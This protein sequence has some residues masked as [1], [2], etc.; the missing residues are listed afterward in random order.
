MHIALVQFYSSTP[1]PDYHEIASSLRAS[2]H[3]VWVGTPNSDGDLAWHD[4]ERVIAIQRGP[5][6]VPQALLRVRLAAMA[7]RRIM[8]LRFMRSVR[9]F[10]REASPDIVQVNPTIGAFLLPLF[11]PK[12]IR[13]ILDIRQINDGGGADWIGKLRDR[14]AIRTWRIWTGTIYDRACFATAAGARRVLG[15]GWSRW[16]SIVPVGVDQRFMSIDRADATSRGRE[17]PI[18]F[19]YVGTL[20]KYRRLERILFAVKRMVQETRDFQV[21]FLGPDHAEGFYQRL[22]DELNLNAV[23]TISPPV[24]YHDVPD[25]VSRYD[26][27]LAYVPCFPAWRY[28]PTIKV[29]EYR[30]LGMPMAATDIESNRE[31]VEDGVN[32]VLVEDSAEGLAE[33]M[34]RFVTD[35]EFLDRCTA[36]AQ[37]MRQGMTWSEV[38]KMY[39]Q[40]VYLRCQ[41]RRNLERS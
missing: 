3:T 18:R 27:A 37:K 5:A 36:N 23:V 29:L 25:A 21:V 22:V 31:F 13:F 17:H 9:G 38:A 35:R 39:E 1:T 20:S 30:A 16:A 15:E 32:G 7:L 12:R 41:A 19:I 33:G 40:D 28:Q 6:R 4:G 8:Y 10:L 2:G 26:V 24:R 14:M 11:M 34:L